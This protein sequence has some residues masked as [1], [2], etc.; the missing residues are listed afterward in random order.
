M[1]LSENSKIDALTAKTEAGKMTVADLVEK[2]VELADAETAK[3]VKAETKRLL[4]AVKETVAEAVAEAKEAGAKES[5]KLLTELGKNIAEAA[6]A[7]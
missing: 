4:I 6:K 2:L 1:S 7:E 3:A 5:A